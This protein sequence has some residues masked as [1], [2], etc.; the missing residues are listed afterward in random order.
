[1][2][3]TID[4]IY[5]AFKKLKSAKEEENLAE[6]IRLEEELFLLR[7]E[8]VKNSNRKGRVFSES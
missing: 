2:A 7:R 6:I 4:L 1:M 5:E 3:D 8:L